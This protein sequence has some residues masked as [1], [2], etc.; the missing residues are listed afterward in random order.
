MLE[1]RSSRSASSRELFDESS[2]LPVDD[3]PSAALRHAEPRSRRGT[4]DLPEIVVLTPG[5][6]N[7]AYFEHCFLAQQMGAE[8]VEGSRP[9]RRRR[10]LRLHADDRRP[11]ARRRHLPPH[12]RRLPRPRG[13]PPRLDS[14]RAG[15]DAG[16][17]PGKV[18]TRQRAGRR[19]RR[20][21]GRV[22]L[23]ARRSSGTTWAR[24]AILPNVP[25]L[26]VRSTTTSAQC[27]LEHLDELV[28]KPANESGGYGM[29]IG[30]RGQRERARRVP[31][32]DS[33]PTPA[34]TSPSR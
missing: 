31:S 23:R 12:R 32:A 5:I 9:R 15:P 10:R 24:S 33:R 30:P 34:T 26:R 18:G 21:Q 17:A 25:T 11:A 14:R 8:L 29:L 27:V 7:S 20:R 19:R 2:I 13:L 22:R 28:V 6:Y 1:N 3:Y 16:L 4:G